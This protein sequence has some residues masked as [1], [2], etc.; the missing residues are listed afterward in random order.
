M[1]PLKEKQN[2]NSSKEY[3]IF[4]E[5]WGK[6]KRDRIRNE[7]FKGVGIQNVLIKLE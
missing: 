2:Q 5:Y 1:D 4:S 7:Q 6:T 3:D